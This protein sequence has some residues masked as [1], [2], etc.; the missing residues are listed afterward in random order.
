MSCCVNAIF[1]GLTSFLK[2]FYFVFK[3]C[4]L[5]CLKK[6]QVQ[7]KVFNKKLLRSFL[8][9]PIQKTHHETLL[10]FVARFFFFCRFL[11]N[12][13]LNIFTFDCELMVNHKSIWFYTHLHICST[14]LTLDVSSQIKIHYLQIKPSERGAH[15]N[16]TMM[17]NLYGFVR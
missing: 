9:S 3:K 2:N 8:G 15:N 16:R 7:I 13:I 1:R 6:I 14:C 4:T 10:N 17:L 12:S 5:R 11:K